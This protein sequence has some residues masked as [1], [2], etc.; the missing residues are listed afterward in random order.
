[1]NG[2]IQID[3]V[4]NQ[5]LVREPAIAYSVDI[6]TF[7]NKRFLILF[8]L[9][10]GTRMVEGHFCSETEPSSLDFINTLRLS[11]CIKKK[12]QLALIHTDRG[13]QFTSFEVI[14]FAQNHDLII[15]HTGDKFRNQVSE[16]FNRTIKSKMRELIIDQLIID[17]IFPP[18]KRKY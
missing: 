4:N 1:L 7:I 11:V 13:A 15:S 2:N 10:L 9:D 3:L 6:T 14:D 18:E 5:Y 8:I 12:N 17:G 16:R